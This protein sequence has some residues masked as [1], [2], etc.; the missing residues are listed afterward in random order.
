MGNNPVSKSDPLGD[1]EDGCCGG[2]IDA[3]KQWLDDHAER[4]KNHTTYEFN[5]V[6]DAASSAIDQAGDNFKAR[7][8]AKA[9]PLHQILANPLSIIGGPAGEEFYVAENVLGLEANSAKTVASTE[10]K[11]VVAK[12]T[13]ELAT[14]VHGNSLQSTKPTTLY[15]LEKSTGEHLKTGITSKANPEKRYSNAFMKDKKMTPLDKGTRS[16]MAKKEREIVEKNPGPLNREPWAGK[17]KE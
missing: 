13:E 15:R 6:K 16:E 12:T 4:F 7:W 5:A 2:L 8:E 10:V 11:T 9:D 17:K 1:V 3:A 14:K